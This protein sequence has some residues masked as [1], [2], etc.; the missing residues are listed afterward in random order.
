MIGGCIVEVIRQWKEKKGGL[1][2]D[3]L[4]SKNPKEFP[5]I[6]TKFAYVLLGFNC[7]GYNCLLSWGYV[8][9]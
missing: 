1:C 2:S 5:P 6:K 4:K 7:L 3:W 9:S 8:V